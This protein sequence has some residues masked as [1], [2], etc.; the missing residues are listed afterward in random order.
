[1]YE[2]GLPSIAGCCMIRL[3]LTGASCVLSVELCCE[4]RGASGGRVAILDH[5]GKGS[6][7]IR[8]GMEGYYQR[9][10]RFAED[11]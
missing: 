7:G 6:G 3:R 1:M 4:G 11:F 10:N 9:P 8:E 2:T 5:V